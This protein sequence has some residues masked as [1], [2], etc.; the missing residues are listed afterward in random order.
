MY[1]IVPP[2]K[3]HA[4]VINK[5]DIE[6]NQ[7]LTN[8][9]NLNKTYIIPTTLYYTLFQTRFVA[10]KMMENAKRVSYYA[11]ISCSTRCL[12]GDLLYYLIE[13]IIL[14]LNTL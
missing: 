4:C 7:T 9:Y 6:I 11:M 12:Q 1:A 10:D 14:L 3:Y 8:L 2:L 5:H 13:N